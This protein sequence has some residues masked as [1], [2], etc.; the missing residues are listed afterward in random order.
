MI[1]FQK[2]ISMDNNDQ[3]NPDPSC[4]TC[5]FAFKNKQTLNQHK[6]LIT[7]ANEDE[8]PDFFVR[9]EEELSRLMSFINFG[10]SSKK[11][12]HFC[13]TTKTAIPGLYP[14]F[15]PVQRKNSYPVLSQLGNVTSSYDFL[16]KSA[17]ETTV[18]LRRSV[19]IKLG[20]NILLI[21][22]TLLLPSSQQKLRSFSTTNTTSHLLVKENRKRKC[23]V[24][25]S[26][27]Y[28]N[29]TPSTLKF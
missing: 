13:E 4:P 17:R 26:I 23:Q 27:L 5:L 14:L 28:L 22:P 10:F 21:N 1:Y 29:F 9:E 11:L 18:K 24:R 20:H 19:K 16:R 12:I 2:R 6:C 7:F 15:F 25:D 8:E 3:N